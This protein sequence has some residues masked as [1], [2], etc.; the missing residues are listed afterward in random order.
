[1]EHT[2][3]ANDVPSDWIL[4]NPW[5]WMLIGL[6]LELVAFGWVRALD[7]DGSVVRFWL[8]GLGLLSVGGALTLRLRSSAP[9]Y[10]ERMPIGARSFILLL[11]GLFHGLLAVGVTAALFLSFFSIDTIGW[12]P[13]QLVVLW[14][15]VVPMSGAAAAVCFARLKKEGQVTRAEEASVLLTLTAF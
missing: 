4:S 8:I 13:G 5:L 12:R 10:L 15:V 1:M 2:E 6:S 11:L 14:F 3:T 7:G 9:A